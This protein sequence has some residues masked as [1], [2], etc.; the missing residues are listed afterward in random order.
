MRRVSQ[1]LTD[2]EEAAWRKP[3]EWTAVIQGKSV[4][5]Q[6]N[7][8]RKVPKITTPR[9]DITEF[10]RKSRLRMLKRLATVD[11]QKIGISQFITLTYPDEVIHTDRHRRNRER[12]LIHRWIES[13]VG[14]QVSG[15]WRVEWKP[16]LSGVNKGKVLPHSHMLIFGSGHLDKEEVRSEWGRV[17]GKVKWVEVDVQHVPEGEAIACYVSKYCGKEEPPGILDNVPY[18]NKTG[19]HYGYLRR[20]KIPLHSK[21]VFLLREKM[22]IDFLKGKASTIIPG[23]DT[24]YCEGFTLLGEAAESVKEEIER[25]GVAVQS[26]IG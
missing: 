14:W 17:I 15:V 13:T 20:D 25:I 16:R 11:W 2:V 24:R 12:Y 19:R 4:K 26:S 22:L 10:S 8:Y 3:G 18:V 1:I 7:R 5:V 9:G 21:K 6:L 23:Y